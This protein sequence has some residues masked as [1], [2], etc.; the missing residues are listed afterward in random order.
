ML[1]FH[2][3]RRP[4][5]IACIAALAFA[6][7]CSGPAAR[8]ETP[9][10]APPPS[11]IT[12]E[13]IQPERSFREGEPIVVT[14]R[15][16]NTS[17][18]N[19][20]TVFF[21]LDEGCFVRVQP[22]PMAIDDGYE[23][24]SHDPVQLHLGAY[25][26]HLM[27]I[28]LLQTGLFHV[29]LPHGDYEVRLESELRWFGRGSLRDV[30]F[31]SNAIKLKITESASSHPPDVQLRLV[32]PEYA[33]YQGEPIMLKA[34]LTNTSKQDM[35][36]LRFA[37]MG[38]EVRTQITRGKGA[39]SVSSRTHIRV[40]PQ[41][42]EVNPRYRHIYKPATLQLPPESAA[43]F[44]FGMLEELCVRAWKLPP[45]EYKV[46]LEHNRSGVR[47]PECVLPEVLLKSNELT[48]IVV[49]PDA[50]LERPP[51]QLQMRLAQPKDPFVEGEPIVLNVSVTNTSEK[52]AGLIGFNFRDYEE[53]RFKSYG[54]EVGL[55]VSV[56]T[57]VEPWPKGAKTRYAELEYHGVALPAKGKVEFE[58][59]LL[60]TSFGPDRYPPGEYKLSFRFH[61]P[62]I[63]GADNR[64]TA[65]TGLWIHSNEIKLRV[66][67]RTNEP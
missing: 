52:D 47:S 51:M 8:N 19:F 67:A 53:P 45:G 40:V 64:S 61:W 5:S 46:S 44:E 21:G 23:T 9:V 38:E 56:W 13:L 32:Q 36:T 63:N 20:G 12:L 30:S 28:D 37:F 11:P 31:E 65:E 42:F 60:K 49:E 17:G 39:L 10:A 35:G 15:I 1:I 4:A 3:A 55:Q 58:V 62:R 27:Q 22:A 50:K 29:R 24:F 43:E 7:G 33:F 66:V 2:R 25:A 6:L 57:D 59:D 26:C 14:A 34:R 54:D 41:P 18:T 48:I 16:A